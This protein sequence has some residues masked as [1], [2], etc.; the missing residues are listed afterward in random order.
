MGK[1]FP[2]K[3]TLRQ[4]ISEKFNEEVAE[5]HGF[6]VLHALTD[7]LWIEK[8]AEASTCAE[9]KALLPQL[10]QI[11]IRELDRLRSSQVLL[12]ELVLNYHLSQDPEEYQT[13]TLNTTVARELVGRGVTLHLEESVRYVITEYQAAVPSD[14]ARA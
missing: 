2:Y 6:R 12:H 3:R 1:C 7:S 4:D 11:I 9:R 5:S 10:L 8:L 13:D 14:R